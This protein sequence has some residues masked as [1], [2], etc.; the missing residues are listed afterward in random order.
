MTVGTMI[1]ILMEDGCTLNEAVR[2]IRIGVEIFEADELKEHLNEYLNE[3]G[4]EDAADDEDHDGEPYRQM[5]NGGK[6][7]DDW[8]RIEMNGKL[9]YIAYVL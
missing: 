7:V 6:V 4:V 2:Q 9:Y 1:D 5:V 3:W 8:S